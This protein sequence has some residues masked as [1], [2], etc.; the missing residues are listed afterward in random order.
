MAFKAAE[1]MPSMFSREAILA[2]FASGD[3]DNSLTN[4]KQDKKLC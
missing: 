2:T 1:D 4:G 3:M